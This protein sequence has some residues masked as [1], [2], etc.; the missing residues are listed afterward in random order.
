MF[1]RVYLDNSATT[2]IDP[3]VLAAMMPFLT[4][5]YGNA[6][7]IHHFGQT[8]RAAVDKARHQVAGLLNAR[9]NEIV[10]T[11]GGTEANNLA[12]RGTLEANGGGHIITSA[13]EHSAVKSVC[14]DLGK[15]GVEVTYLP[16]YEDGIVR[17]D[18]IKN[19]F[20]ENTLLI[21]IMAANNEIGTIQ[22]IAEIGKFVAELRK[23]GKK[24]F[25]HTD[26][27]QAAGKISVDVEEIGCDLLSISGHKIYAPKGIGA[28]YVRRR[29]RLHPQ[30]IGG[31]QERER[32]GG[33]EAVPNIVAFGKA[34]ELAAENLQKDAAA[35]FALRNRFEDLV[36]EQVTGTTLNGS[37]EHRLPNIS[38]VMFSGIDGEGLLINLDMQGIAVSTGSACS[39]GS[40]EPS[41]VIKALGAPDDLAR[42]AVRFSFGKYN[43]DED[44]DR[45]IEVL[46]KAVEILRSLSPA[47]MSK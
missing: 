8:A 22:P 35:L 47:K 4:E 19:A 24:I 12:I 3:E 11:S 46:P 14:E 28:L 30:N 7:S 20:R 1:R 34:C 45:V 10:F 37:S 21:S 25:F 40:I 41:P 6:S 29:V 44:I 42:G 2:P 33:T 17:F 15:R 16:V 18:D 43:T 26:A 32:R 23:D 38:N 36:F 39:S 9:P 13:I 5:N 31:R 27:V